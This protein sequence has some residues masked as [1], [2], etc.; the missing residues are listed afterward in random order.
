[1]GKY[2]DKVSATQAQQETGTTT[3]APVTPSVQQYHA[4]AVKV[5]F[6]GSVSGGTPSLDLSYNVTSVTD[7]GVGQFTISFTNAFSTIN[8][9]IASVG[10]NSGGGNAVIVKASAQVV[11]SFQLRYS[12]NDDSVN[13]DPATFWGMA[14]GDQ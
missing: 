5:W 8:Y 4:S 10:D 11:G 12:N 1:M 3:D 9:A 2:Y 7:D 14:S 13:Q 6:R